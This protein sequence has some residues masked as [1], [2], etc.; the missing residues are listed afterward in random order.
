[1]LSFEKLARKTVKDK[2]GKG[3]AN[4]IRAAQKFEVKSHWLIL[5]YSPLERQVCVFKGMT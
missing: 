5:K 1:M 2:A 3:R 4:V